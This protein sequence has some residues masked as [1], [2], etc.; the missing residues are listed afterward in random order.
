MHVVGELSLCDVL[1]ETRLL[2]HIVKKLTNLRV[3]LVKENTSPVFSLQ[4]PHESE[5]SEESALVLF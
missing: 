1:H 3:E 2:A 5:T 4:E